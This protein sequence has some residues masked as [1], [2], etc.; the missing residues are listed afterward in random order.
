M[1][2]TVSGGAFVAGKPRLWTTMHPSGPMGAYGWDVAA[3]GFDPDRP[4]GSGAV[5]GAPNRAITI[6]LCGDCNERQIAAHLE[7]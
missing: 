1:P 3:D 4:G 2:Y 5:A 7:G 6:T